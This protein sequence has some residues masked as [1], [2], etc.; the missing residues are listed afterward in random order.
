LKLPFELYINGTDGEIED[1][2][3]IYLDIDHNQIKWMLKGYWLVDPRMSMTCN[4]FST[5]RYLKV[6]FFNQPR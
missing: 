5:S 2:T 6:F 3:E 4:F 1:T